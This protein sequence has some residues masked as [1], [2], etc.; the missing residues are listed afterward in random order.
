MDQLRTRGRCYAEDAGCWWIT[1]I[2]AEAK[3]EDQQAAKRGSAAE[4]ISEPED[5]SSP[6]LPT[7]GLRRKPREQVLEVSLDLQ[8]TTSLPKT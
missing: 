7:D 1:V 3:P 4:T 6:P 2:T 5:Q 8:P